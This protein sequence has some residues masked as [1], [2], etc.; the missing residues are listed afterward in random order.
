MLENKVETAEAGDE[1]AGNAVHHHH[2][3]EEHHESILYF[4]LT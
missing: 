4:L 2:G 3:Q 1:G